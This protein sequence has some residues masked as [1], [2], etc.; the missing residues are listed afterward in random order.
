MV[1]DILD[2]Y[3]VLDGFPFF[4]FGMRILSD[5]L[6]CRCLSFVSV[7]FARFGVQGELSNYCSVW[8]LGVL[9]YGVW[10]LGLWV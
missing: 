6:A 1:Q 9:G 10:D 5:H 8:G 2:P 3:H 4:A 7:W